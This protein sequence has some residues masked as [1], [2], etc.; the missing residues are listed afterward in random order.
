MRDVVGFS[1][2]HSYLNAMPYSLLFGQV[3]LGQT[4]EYR[5]TCWNPSCHCSCV[6]LPLS[7][8]RYWILTIPQ[9]SLPAPLDT[10][11]LKVHFGSVSMAEEMAIGWPDI[12]RRF[13]TLPRLSNRISNSTL[14]ARSKP[15][16]RP[17]VFRGSIWS[18]S[19]A[20]PSDPSRSHHLTFQRC[21]TEP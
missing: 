2:S 15:L 5:T 9:P 6:E 14:P 21:N 17:D 10:T 16:S 4:E 7:P 19:C 12:A 3:F 1:V 13:I 11:G 18:T 8:R 20:S